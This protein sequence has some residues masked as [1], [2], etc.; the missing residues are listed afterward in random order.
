MTSFLPAWAIAP[1][2]G[3][4]TVG[5]WLLLRR[6]LGVSGVLARFSRL[7]EE[8][9]VDAGFDAMESNPDALQAAMAAM[10]AEEFGLSPE[11]AE[12]SLEGPETPRAA[13]LGTQPAAKAET[14]TMEAPLGRA[15][16][17]TPS[18]QEHAIFL[19][20]LA[21]GGLVAALV[22]GTFGATG[23]GM[24]GEFSRLVGTGGRGIAALGVG[25]VMV[26]FGTALSGGCTAGHGLT[27]CG[28]LMSGS[29]VSTAVFFT[30][31][32]AFSFLL[33]GLA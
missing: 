21:A 12:V 15:C 5:Y 4:I 1:A 19:A 23:G 25:G 33:S 26:G 8:A 18:L 6:P 22:R 2:L 28:R 3:A 20:A 24:G 17:S 14:E 11:E 16:A 9:A 29:L 10:T 31:A 13:E 7:R 30:A 27:G 32:V